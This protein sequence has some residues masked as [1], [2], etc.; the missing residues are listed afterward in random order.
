MTSATSKMLSCLLTAAVGLFAAASAHAQVCRVTE[1]GTSSGDGSHWDDEPMDLHTALGD[2]GCSEIWIKAGVY[3]PHPSSQAGRFLIVRNV[4]V[5]GGF[6]GNETSRSERDPAAH[7]TV[8]SG[9]IDNDDIVDSQGVTAHWSDQ[10]GS[11]SHSVL[12]VHGD[13]AGGPITAATVLDG[14]IITAAVASGFVCHAHTADSECSPTLNTVSFR[15][16]QGSRGGGMSNNANAAGAVSSPTLEDV[17][18]SG[19]Q[20]LEGGGMYNQAIFGGVSSPV[21][22]RTMFVGN[23]G[24]I[25]LT[26]GE[27][28]AMYNLAV[29]SAVSSPKLFDVTFHDNEAGRGGAVANY[30]SGSS[31]ISPEF[32]RVTFSDNRAVAPNGYFGDGGAMATYVGAAVGY[33]LLENVTFT[34]NSSSFRDGGA[35]KN[36]IDS[37]PTDFLMTLNHVTFTGNSAGHWGGAIMNDE[38]LPGNPVMMILNNVIAWGNTA[39]PTTPG[40]PDIEIFNSGARPVVN[41]SIV[42]DGCPAL[43][44][45]CSNVIDLDPLLGPLAD[46]GGLTR[47]QLPAAN[48]PA[49]D[50]GNSATCASADQRGVARTQGGACDIGAVER[51][52]AVELSVAVAGQGEVDAEP[53]PAPFIDG[54]V[55]CDAAGAGQA[56][57]RA[58]YDED[59]NDDVIL[60][61]AP[62]PGWHVDSASGCNGR[63]S[64]STWRINAITRDCL[65]SVIFVALP[66]TIFQNG[67]E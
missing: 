11:N 59:S 61:L 10:R 6:A 48:S 36:L 4:Q 15:G 38:M 7:P 35:I 67:F 65:V 21:L 43:S 30:A 31:E 27:G 5:Y 44:S 29:S 62:T 2:D 60:T 13:M 8:L 12:I 34:G 19:N 63:R 18:F 23:S 55:A 58:T 66:P 51:I 46:N 25:P 24:K 9:D 37:P 42:K 56:H 53:T 40:I 64:G 3:K 54:I 16:N 49:I 22:R 17:T 39:T 50:A 20:A 28:G 41:D 14:L 52:Q 32:Y 45:V 26:L 1:A 33:P 47:T 57:C